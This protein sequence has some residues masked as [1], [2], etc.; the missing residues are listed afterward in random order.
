[1]R[2]G[3]PATAVEAVSPRKVVEGLCSGGVWVGECVPPESSVAG[4]GRSSG[5][6]VDADA[7]VPPVGAETPP[8]GLHECRSGRGGAVAG[9]SGSHVVLPPEKT[10]PEFG[11]RRKDHLCAHPLLVRLPLHPTC[12]V[13]PTSSS[14]LSSRLAGPWFFPSRAP[15]IPS[16]PS[17]KK[18]ESFNPFLCLDPT[19]YPISRATFLPDP[20]LPQVHPFQ[21]LIPYLNLNV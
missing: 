12:N 2:G 3:G 1:M 15:S 20:T 18:G 4:A 8:A 11:L 21:L 6:S 16:S 7:G 13:D 9:K 19:G 17:P 14:T 10:A 5:V